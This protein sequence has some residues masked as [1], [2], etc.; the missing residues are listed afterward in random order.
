MVDW[1]GDFGVKGFVSW[2]VEYGI[3]GRRAQRSCKILHLRGFLACMLLNKGPQ[4]RPP[5]YD[6]PY[7][8]KPPKG[9]PNF[10]K[11]PDI[12]MHTYTYLC[13]NFT[14]IACSVFVGHTLSPKP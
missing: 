8:R 1:V 3:L 6:N 11:R 12:D 13:K 4:D 2:G 10:G 7:C 9:T 14:I 5:K